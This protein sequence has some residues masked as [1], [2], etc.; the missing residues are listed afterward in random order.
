M[1]DETVTSE[2]QMTLES[3]RQQ[4]VEEEYKKVEVAMSLQTKQRTCLLVS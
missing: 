1:T 3:E 4:T 2:L